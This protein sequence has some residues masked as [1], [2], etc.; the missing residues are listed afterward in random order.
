MHEPKNGNE[1]EILIEIIIALLCKSAAPSHDAS[2]LPGL[3]PAGGTHEIFNL[4]SPFYFTL[5]VLL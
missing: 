5:F 1:G 2:L 4:C 3:L